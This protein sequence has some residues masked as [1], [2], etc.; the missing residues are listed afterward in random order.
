MIRKITVL[1]LLSVFMTSAV[2]L[3]ANT[4]L[5]FRPFLLFPGDDDTWD[6]AAGFEA[7]CVFWTTSNF[8]IAVAAGL[9]K[10]NVTD[11]I[12][13]EPGYA[14]E[15]DGDATVIPFGASVLFRPL[16]VN[17]QIILTLEG[18]LRYAIVNS[19]IDVVATDYEYIYGDEVDI[20]NGLIGILGVD[21]G[22]PF[23]Q[24]ASLSFGAGYQ[25]DIA[26]GDAEWYGINIGEN[27]LKGLMLNFGINVKL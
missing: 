25:F 10:W 18:G 14:V 16:P 7:Q 20:D 12:Y 26:K 8:G 13:T 2:C 27:E 17:S 1:L 11:G 22:I 21:V 4:E 9:Q 5:R 3:A 23:S 24:K 6:D 19:D 15:A